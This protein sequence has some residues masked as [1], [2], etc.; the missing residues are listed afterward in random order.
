MRLATVFTYILLFSLIASA[1]SLQ[2]KSHEQIARA[3]LDAIKT[4]NF[5]KLQALTPPLNVWRKFNP[6]ESK[7]YSDARLMRLLK[8]NYYPKLRRDFDNIMLSA[9]RNKINLSRLEF[10]EAKLQKTEGSSATPF[11]DVHYSYGEKKGSFSLALDMI[12][13]KYYLH[14]ILLSMMRLE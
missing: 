3:F 6:A 9:K 8:K 7:K 12:D 1:R 13:E 4:S 11:L 14:E 2:D 5:K 10:V